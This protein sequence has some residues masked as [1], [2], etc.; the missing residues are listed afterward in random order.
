M[1]NRSSQYNAPAGLP[2]S[3]VAASIV[4]ILNG[5]LGLFF[6]LRFY[7]VLMQFGALNM[8]FASFV[9]SVSSFIEIAFLIVGGIAMLNR[10]RWGWCLALGGSASTLF[11]LLEL[12]IFYG[13]NN[14]FEGMEMMGVLRVVG[15]CLALGGVVL[16]CIPATFQSL[17]VRANDLWLGLG[18]AGAVLVVWNLVQ[19][20]QRM[21]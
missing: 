11:L 7:W 21:F 6:I 3:T 8:I 15:W 9:S 12:I 17:K 1:D 13:V 18:L 2:G 14:P 20:T 5:L 10:Q 4:V 19:L 16:L